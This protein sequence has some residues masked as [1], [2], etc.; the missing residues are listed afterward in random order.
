MKRFLFSITLLVSCVSHASATREEYAVRNSPCENCILIAVI[1]HGVAEGCEGRY[2]LPV[3][4]TVQ[5][6]WKERPVELFHP[7]TLFS[8]TRKEKDGKEERFV[9]YV[10]S[11]DPS[12]F[13]LQE[14]DIL[15]VSQPII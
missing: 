12:V 3:G 11:E 10:R 14:G 6:F 5:R 9:I 15:F 1:G 8:V 2:Y 7:H 13:V 4:Y